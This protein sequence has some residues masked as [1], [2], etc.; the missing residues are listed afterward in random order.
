MTEGKVRWLAEMLHLA[1][2]FGRMAVFE[3]NLR[4]GEAHWSPQ[5]FRLFGFEPGEQPP[6]SEEAIARVH[7]DDRERA[8]HLAARFSKVPGLHEHRY[9]LVDAQGGIREIHSLVDVRAG[10]DGQP[11]LMLGVNID[12][13]DVIRSMR[14]QEQ[15]IDMITRAAGVGVWT[16]DIESDRAEWNDEMFRIYGLPQDTPL[17]ANALLERVVHPDDRARVRGQRELAAKAGKEGVQFDFRIVRPDGQVRWVSNWSRREQ[18]PDGR[19]TAYGVTMDVTERLEALARVRALNERAMLVAD[20]AGIGVW[21]R[22]LSTR[23]SVWNG[24]MYRLRGVSPDSGMTLEEVRRATHHPED[25]PELDRKFVD[26]ELHGIDYDHEFRVV[27]PD[28]SLHWLASR[29]VARRDDSGRIVA[30]SGVNWD[31]TEHKRAEQAL[32][33]KASAEQANRAKSEFLSR[34]S[35]ELRTP[36]NA[37]LGFAQMVLRDDAAPLAGPQLERVRHIEAAGLHLMSLIDDVLDLASVESNRLKLDVQAVDLQAVVD[38]VLR[39]T[40]QQAQAAGVTVQVERIRAWVQADPGRL[41]QIVA[42]LVT[43]AIKF[44]RPQGGQVWIG[45][46]PYPVQDADGWQLR[47]RD[48]GR[49]ISEAHRQHLFEPFNRLG[50]DRDGIAGTGIGLA[51]VRH[52]VERMAGTIEVRSTEGAG[53]EF[54]VGLPAAA[55]P[56]RPDPTPAAAL[57]PAGA[58]PLLVLYI[59]DNAVNALLVS[60]LMALRPQMRLLSAG[61]GA[62]G[63]ATAIEQRPDVVLVDMQLPDFDG[64]EVLRRLRDEPGLADCAFIALSASA[65]PDDIQRALSAGFSDY[66]TKPIDF[67]RFLEGLDALAVRRS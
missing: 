29:G 65:M 59:E 66:W 45:A 17:V 2:E 18:S 54:R 13:T 20:S 16:I 53:S 52:L 49:G 42:N 7:P 63:V 44:N 11:E 33:E 22:D 23:T 5:M 36:L 43:N 9:R 19:L 24:Q 27:W 60:Q 14:A 37:V 64:Y 41:R 21:E 3:R 30:L 8:V 46:Q 34:M 32:R 40:Q 51:I 35:H 55:A 56:V 67:E 25:A 31:I 47:V 50:A 58:A 62:S 10:A 48:N 28:G 39:W 15:R 4:T 12:D 1:Q 57:A 38:D 6:S 61:D 26:A